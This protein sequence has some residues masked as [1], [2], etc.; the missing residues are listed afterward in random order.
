MADES[1]GTSAIRV[2]A[3]DCEIINNKYIMQ[4]TAMDFS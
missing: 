1:N 3:K 2:D 4:H